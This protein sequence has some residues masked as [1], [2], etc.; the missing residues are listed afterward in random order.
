MGSE[1]IEECPV[2]TFIEG[3][4]CL[5]YNEF[6]IPFPFLLT[7]IIL[8]I[9]ILIARCRGHNTRFVISSIAM[10]G[11]VEIVAWAYLLYLFW[12][13]FAQSRGMAMLGCFFMTLCNLLM[14]VGYM[15]WIRH[16]EAFK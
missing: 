12:P 5:N 13:T 3:S 4:S 7:S 11:L 16:D 1:C 6:I 2:G 10:I 15:K 8:T 9:G 14:L